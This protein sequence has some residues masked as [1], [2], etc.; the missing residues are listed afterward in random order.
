M[1]VWRWSVREENVTCGGLHP[2][3]S[4]GLQRHFRIRRFLRGRV[5]GRRGCMQRC[6]FEAKT[7]RVRADPPAC[8]EDARARIHFDVA[9]V[10]TRLQRAVDFAPCWRLAVLVRA[11]EAATRSPLRAACGPWV[12]RVRPDLEWCQGGAVGQLL[13]QQRPDVGQA[14]V[15]HGRLDAVR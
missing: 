13:P 5:S 8:V 15:R 14:G 12:G 7:L 1:Y 10:P 3:T 11:S 6:V 9:A 2:P 4:R